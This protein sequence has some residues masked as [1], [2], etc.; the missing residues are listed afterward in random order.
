MA[1]GLGIEP[2]K[3][4]DAYR[5]L[6]TERQQKALKAT[7]RRN[8]LLVLAVAAPLFFFVAYQVLNPSKPV[9]YAGQI[10]VALNDQLSPRNPSGVLE[11]A[12]ANVM[13][14]SVKEVRLFLQTSIGIAVS[15]TKV[16][17][18]HTLALEIYDP[19]G[20]L[21]TRHECEINKDGSRTTV[22]AQLVL[23]LPLTMSVSDGWRVDVL[24]DE[25]KKQSTPLKVSYGHFRTQLTTLL[26]KDDRKTPQNNKTQFSISRDTRVISY[27]FWDLIAKERSGKIQWRWLRPDGSLERNPVLKIEPTIALGWYRAHSTLDLKPDSPRGSWKVEVIFNDVLLDVL[28]FEVID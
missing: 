1:D 11:L 4:E 28:S 22:Y 21:Y 7:Q 19:Q 20:Q 24:V 5:I 16:Q 10:Q 27:S 23:P 15:L 26:G 17:R 6:E 2:S 18:Q 9:P 25:V 8:L 14:A 12:G 13:T 3:V